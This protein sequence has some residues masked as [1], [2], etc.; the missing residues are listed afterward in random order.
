M[1]SAKFGMHTENE[2]ERVSAEQRLAFAVINTAL[3]DF[4][5]DFTRYELAITRRMPEPTLARMRLNFHEPLMFLFGRTETS[6]F[7]FSVAKLPFVPVMS[8]EHLYI[9]VSTKQKETRY[10]RSRTRALPNQTAA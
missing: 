6:V 4:L 3:D 10:E 2:D 9:R 1:V 7:W 5:R 8:A